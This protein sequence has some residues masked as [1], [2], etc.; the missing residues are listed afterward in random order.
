VRFCI[1]LYIYN[2]HDLSFVVCVGIFLGFTVAHSS[3]LAVC[4]FCVDGYPVYFGGA[5]FVAYLP[6][7]I[8]FR[9]AA[10]A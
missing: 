8:V 7:F 2:Q 5:A 6:L 9:A 4:V 1:W 3:S 10:L